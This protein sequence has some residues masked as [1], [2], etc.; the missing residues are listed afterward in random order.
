MR[1][2]PCVSLCIGEEA[3]PLVFVLVEGTVELVDEAKNLL[4][5]ATRIAG[6]HGLRPSRG[7]REV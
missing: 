6:V 2:D 1:R 5:Q 3:P 7:V 4:Y